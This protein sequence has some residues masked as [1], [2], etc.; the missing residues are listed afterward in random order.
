MTNDIS[1]TS[2]SA[3]KIGST[4]KTAGLKEALHTCMDE[5]HSLK[6]SE[7]A[8]AMND[9]DASFKVMM[10]IHNKLVNAYNELN[11]S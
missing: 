7:A 2:V 1:I 5:L 9:A 8:A 6:P 3:Q 4:H 11:K 10:E